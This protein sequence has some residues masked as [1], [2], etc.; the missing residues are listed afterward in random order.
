MESSIGRAKLSPIN[1]AILMKVANFALQ[2]SFPYFTR[3]FALKNGK[4]AR[5][6]WVVKKQFL[7]V[8]FLTAVSKEKG[9]YG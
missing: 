1:I 7:L 2:P 5:L 4:V 6:Q 3:V 9:K 8:K